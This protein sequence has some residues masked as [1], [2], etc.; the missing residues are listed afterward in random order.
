LTQQ[1][2]NIKNGS[3]EPPWIFKLGHYR[4]PGHPRD[5]RLYVHDWSVLVEVAGIMPIFRRQR[6]VEALYSGLSEQWGP[7]LRYRTAAF[8]GNQGRKLYN[9][10]SQL[11][12]CLREIVP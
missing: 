7:S 4:V 9:E 12:E 6:E 11:Y 3:P 1:G 5:V 8:A 2:A 10:L